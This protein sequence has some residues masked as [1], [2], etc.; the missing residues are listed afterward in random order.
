MITIGTHNGKFHADEVMALAIF[1]NVFD[2]EINI[3]RSR[4]VKHLSDCDILVDIGSKYD[5]DKRMYDHHMQTKPR[6][7]NGTAYASAGLIWKHYGKRV[8]SKLI[9]DSNSHEFIFDYID[10]T[11]MQSIDM[12]DNGDLYVR[13][14]T[15]TSVISYWNDCWYEVDDSDMAFRDAIDLSQFLLQRAIKFGYGLYLSK[16][17]VLEAAEKDPDILVF[18]KFIPAFNTIFEQSL[19]HKFIIFKDENGNWRIQ[20]IPPD[21]EHPFDQRCPLPKSWADAEVA[22]LPKISGIEDI[23][24]VHPKQFIGGAKSY[25]SAMKMAKLAI[26]MNV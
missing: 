9:E 19:K 17:L 4:D 14:L 2:K 26:E 5:H 23:I 13:A 6:R 10:R 15:F 16:S 7:E 12:M 22:D 3:V 21:H 8:L 18:D 1:D 11:I 25:E 24:F 20:C